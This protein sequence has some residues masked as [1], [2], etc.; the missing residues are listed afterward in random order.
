MLVFQMVDN[1]IGG[2]ALTC[3]WQAMQQG[4][5]LHGALHI[6]SHIKRLVQPDLMP[7]S[8]PL[9]RKAWQ[10]FSIHHASLTN[11][12]P[13]DN[14]TALMNLSQIQQGSPQL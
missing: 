9:G 13:E 1:G 6:I 11:F 7:N 5:S 14:Q 12:G 10:C 2:G 4:L 8:S 3:S